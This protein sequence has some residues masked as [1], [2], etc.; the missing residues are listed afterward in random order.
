MADHER[1]REAYAAEV[2]KCQSASEL[3]AATKEY[4][5]RDKAQGAFAFNRMKKVLKQFGYLDETKV[6]KSFGML[7]KQRA[8]FFESFEQDISNDILECMKD[9]AVYD[10]RVKTSHRSDEIFPSRNGMARIPIVAKK[11]KDSKKRKIP[12]AV[13]E[14]AKAGK[15][16]P[17]R[18]ANLTESIDDSQLTGSAAEIDEKVRSIKASRLADAMAHS[19]YALLG[20]EQ[21]DLI[22][23][24][25]ISCLLGLGEHE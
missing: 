10:S 23:H 11:K 7:G 4:C 9:A 17:K 20:Q 15:L 22:K 24:E 14:D 1:E 18:I 13:I 21:K 19:S 5:N 2:E 12:A 25:W 3:C 8:A 16:T 6:T